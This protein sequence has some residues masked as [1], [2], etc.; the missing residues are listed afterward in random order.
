MP[1]FGTARSAV[2]SPFDSISDSKDNGPLSGL[3]PIQEEPDSE[4]FESEVEFDLLAP[5]ASQNVTTTS[6]NSFL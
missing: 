6:G 1:P 5:D 4:E 3:A 2:L